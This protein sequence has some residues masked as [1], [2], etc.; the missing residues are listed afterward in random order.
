MRMIQTETICPQ[1]D[2]TEGGGH[3][4]GG[5]VELQASC[6]SRRKRGELTHRKSAIVTSCLLPLSFLPIQNNT[7]VGCAK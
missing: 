1:T 6:G 4:L 3:E 2:R 5:Q 7:V